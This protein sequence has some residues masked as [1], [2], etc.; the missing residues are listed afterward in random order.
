MRSF[1]QLWSKDSLGFCT[2]NGTQAVQQQTGLFEDFFH[3]PKSHKTYTRT[4]YFC[5]SCPS[6]QNI[7][8]LIVEP[9]FR[10]WLRPIIK[11]YNGTM[12]MPFPITNSNPSSMVW[13]S[14]WSVLTQN[15]FKAPV[16]S[17]D[18]WVSQCILP[19]GESEK[20]PLG[21][22]DVHNQGCQEAHHHIIFQCDSNS[23][24]SQLINL[25]PRK[26]HIGVVYF[27][28]FSPFLRINTLKIETLDTMMGPSHW[29]PFLLR[30]A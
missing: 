24:S 16:S 13:R 14:Q 10:S 28:R 5:A 21:E 19:H 4:V 27:A 18:S 30:N 6:F 2:N 8:N 23:T 7:L 12:P 11:T 25:E 20:T 17:V 15:L 26:I 29:E 3:K 22:V 1:D 9:R